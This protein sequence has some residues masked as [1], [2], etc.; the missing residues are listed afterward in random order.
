MPGRLQDKVAMITGGNSGI[1]EATARLF[2]KEGAR[3]AILA[4]REEEGRA[5][6]KAIRSEGGTIAFSRAM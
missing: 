4:R 6:E 1:G 2:T 5:V 3:V